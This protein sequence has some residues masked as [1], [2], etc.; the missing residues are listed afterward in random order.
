MTQVE[1]SRRIYNEIRDY[2]RDAR[3]ITERGQFIELEKLNGRV[4]ELCDSVHKLKVED[5]TK[6]QDDLQ[7]LMQELSELQ[8]LFVER[9][10]SLADEITGVGQ[11]KKAAKAYKQQEAVSVRAAVEKESK[12]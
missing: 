7:Q 1:E 5:A 12:E 8:H 3:E 2:I 10:D 6:F 11:H 9:R 4:Q